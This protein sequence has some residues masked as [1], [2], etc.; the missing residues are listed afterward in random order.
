MKNF[1]C[2]KINLGLNIVARRPDGYHDL[3]TVFFPI[4]LTDELEIEPINNQN[5]ATYSLKIKGEAIDGNPDD[6][7]V[8]KA[9]RLLKDE[10]NL[11]AIN[12][13]LTKRIPS[14]AGLGGGSSDAAFMIRLINE[15]F[16]LQMSTEKM[17]KYAA[18]LGAD[19]AF[20]IDG[21]PAYATGIGDNL[22]SFE[23][24][25]A[26]QGHTIVVIKPPIAVSTRDAYAMIKPRKPDICCRDAVMHPI[27][28]WK[29][30]LTND[31]ENP[32]FAHQPELRKIKESLYEQG[33]I[34]AM[35]SGSGS[36]IYGIFDSI[37]EHLN[38]E[39]SYK[40]FKLKVPAK[41]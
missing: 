34:F 16:N 15:Q 9:Y 33:A 25:L 37:P 12:I 6:N 22:S 3:E 13:R 20:F 8:V 2:A 40:I 18:R 26:L 35:M 23:E 24:G 31:F 1:P 32:V 19:C 36:A 41:G 10:Y 4:P 14:Q 21:K 17:K 5:K 39:K 30:L 27:E 7:L 11:P 28:E 38:F 29:Q